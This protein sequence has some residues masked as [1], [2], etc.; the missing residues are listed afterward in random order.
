MKYRAQIENHAHVN[1][2]AQ[3]PYIAYYIR[4]FL[5]IHYDGDNS[6]KLQLIISIIASNEE[7]HF[8]APLKNRE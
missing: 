7:E 8:Y 5:S 1:V 3:V 2:V 6:I 4:H